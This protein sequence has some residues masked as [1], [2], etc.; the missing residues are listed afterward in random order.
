MTNSKFL[1][2]GVLIVGALAVAGHL[3]SPTPMS[4]IDCRTAEAGFIPLQGTRL[5]TVPKQET[6]NLSS[7]DRVQV[8][9][10]GNVVDGYSNLSVLKSDSA[11]AIPVFTINPTDKIIAGAFGT[12]GKRTA[13]DSG[14]RVEGA[15]GV[16]ASVPTADLGNQANV[17]LQVGSVKSFSLSNPSLV[18]IDRG[19]ARYLAQ[20]LEQSADAEA[21]YVLD[22]MLI[23][24]VVTND[25]LGA[26]INFTD[27]TGSAATGASRRELYEGVGAILGVKLLRVSTARWYLDFRNNDRAVNQQALS[28]ISQYER[29]TKRDFRRKEERFFTAFTEEDRL[30][31]DF[32]SPFSNAKTQIS[33]ADG[34][35]TDGSRL[36]V[37]VKSGQY[38]AVFTAIS[39]SQM[40]AFKLEFTID[41]SRPG[42]QKLHLSEER[43]YAAMLTWDDVNLQNIVAFR[44]RADTDAKMLNLERLTLS[45]IDAATLGA[46]EETDDR[47]H[48]SE[49]LENASFD[50]LRKVLDADV[51]ALG[52]LLQQLN[53]RSLTESQ[54]KTLE[55]AATVHENFTGDVPITRDAADLALRDLATLSTRAEFIVFSYAVEEIKRGEW[56][57]AAESL[58]EARTVAAPERRNRYSRLLIASLYQHW[59]ILGDL[60]NCLS[61]NDSQQPCDD[62][63]VGIDEVQANL[64][65]VSEQLRRELTNSPGGGDY[66]AASGQV[67]FNWTGEVIQ[68]GEPPFPWTET[69]FFPGGRATYDRNLNQATLQTDQASFALHARVDIDP[70]VFPWI[71]FDWAAYELPEY[72]DLRSDDTDDQAVQVIVGIEDQFGIEHSLNYVW[73]TNAPVGT[74]HSRIV[75]FLSAAYLLNYLVVTSGVPDAGQEWRQIRRN[76]VEDVKNFIDPN[77]EPRRVIVVVVQSNS[78]WSGAKSHAAIGPI[79]FSKEPYD[80]KLR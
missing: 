79:V 8:A 9:Y 1:L 4:I 27:S 47:K 29:A 40:Y 69:S 67:V 50:P 57:A 77:I 46:V 33:F 37:P 38:S 39:G 22:R 60:A 30:I 74:K 62:V 34:A 65:R 76:I 16:S 21:L 15:I 58:R 32:A 3:I 14:V 64:R 36:T 43:S 17:K 26:D 28:F 72:G 45:L 2:G 10:L 52:S 35:P 41:L 42:S 55:L 11:C 78:Q 63:S 13:F 20:L 51:T 18:Q 59:Q 24:D 7:E 25:S 48:F 44:D 53:G 6:F 70:L 31:F 71:N 12:P 75:G 49:S 54:K 56:D 23:S 68:D 73:D 61:G 80:G 66:N 19:N 5:F